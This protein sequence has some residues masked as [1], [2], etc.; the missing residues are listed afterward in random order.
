M[1]SILIL[2]LSI[3]VLYGLTGCAPKAV[4]QSDLDTPEYH[5]RLGVRSL[6]DGDYQTALT[7]FQRSVDLDRKFARGWSGLGLT[8]A[9][10]KN[11]KEGRDAVDK[12][13]D[14]ARKDEVVWI[15]RG[16]FWTINRDVKDWLERA[17][18]DFTRAL[19]LDPGNE[20]AEYYLGEAYFY[21]L[22]FSQA[23][24]QFAKVVELKGSLA[25]K[26][27]EKWELSQKIVR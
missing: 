8:K 13:I 7:A 2:P 16:R 27:D 5:Y 26:A 19:S 4:S 24:A 1:R 14:L 23:Q 6:D 11:F 25:G 9:Y 21:G 3:I 12:G 18:K 17:E 22:R 15:F 20:S 10:L